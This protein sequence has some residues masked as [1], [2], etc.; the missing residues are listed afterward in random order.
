MEEAV[1]LENE[2]MYGARKSA[3]LLGLEMKISDVEYQGDRSK[4]TFY[5]TA[6]GRIDFRELIKSL[7][8][9]LD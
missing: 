1:A 7:C 3:D 9:N 2:T 8:L 4:A 5:Y 6:N